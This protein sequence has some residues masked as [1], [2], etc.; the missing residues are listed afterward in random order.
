MRVKTDYDG[1]EYITAGKE[2]EIY[3]D[4]TIVDDEGEVIPIIVNDLCP[5]LN[6]VGTWEIVNDS[7]LL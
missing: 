4:G 1:C 5:H 7:E 2:Y 6:E 3:E